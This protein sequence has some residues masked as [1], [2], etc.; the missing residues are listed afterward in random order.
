MARSRTLTC[1]TS[2]HRP[3]RQLPR[4]RL[5]RPGSNGSLFALYLSDFQT[6][7][8]SRQHHKSVRYPDI[9]HNGYY[10][11]YVA[12]QKYHVR[13]VIRTMQAGR[14]PATW[15]GR[16]SIAFAGFTTLA[17]APHSPCSGYAVELPRS[18]K[19][20]DRDHFQ[21]PLDHVLPR[22]FM[23]AVRACLPAIAD[24]EKLR[25]LCPMRH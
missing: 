18:G 25:Q 23:Y 15:S 19:Y 10:V 5:T 9:L 16:P 7:S 24:I 22:L 3:P 13:H 2:N 12:S 4:R 20:R 17:H 8:C 21:I 6:V 14:R 11:K 1:S